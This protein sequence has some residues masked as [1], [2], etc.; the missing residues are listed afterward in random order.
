MTSQTR[1]ITAMQL[2]ESTNSHQVRAFLRELSD[3]AQAGRPRIVIDCSGFRRWDEA[4][5]FLLLFCLEEAIK[6]NGDVKLAA[7]PAEGKAVLES[8]GAARLFKTFATVVEAID[9]FRSRLPGRD[10]P[11]CTS[12][13]TLE[14]P[15]DAA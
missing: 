7:V 15:A 4:V 12:L 14:A 5:L 13:Q 10:T 8:T 2:P 11:P 3:C 6:R 9:S 1:T